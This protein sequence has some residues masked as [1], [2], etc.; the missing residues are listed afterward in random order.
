MAYHLRMIRP[1]PHRERNDV[2]H[3]ITS[4]TPTLDI[5]VRVQLPGALS[6]GRGGVVCFLLFVVHYNHKH[7]T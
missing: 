7:T 5:H 1:Q 4:L 6:R 3:S 2:L